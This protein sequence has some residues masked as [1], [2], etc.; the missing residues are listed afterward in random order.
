MLLCGMC[1][2]ERQDANKV[3]ETL[4]RGEIFSS[5]GPTPRVRKRG[6]KWVKLRIIE[7]W[8][9]PA[10]VLNA[11][12]PN[13]TRARTDIEKER[14]DGATWAVARRICSTPED[15]FQDVPEVA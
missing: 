15:V 4:L 12:N 9:R 14:H 11:D 2:K 8:I 6:S 5:R 13:Y 10:L 1:D 3:R 7:E